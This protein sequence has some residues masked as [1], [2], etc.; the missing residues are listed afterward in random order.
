MIG[1]L[2]EFGEDGQELVVLHVSPEPVF[3]ELV[4]SGHLVLEGLHLVQL[5]M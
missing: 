1:W 4:V 2:D 5:L 3:V